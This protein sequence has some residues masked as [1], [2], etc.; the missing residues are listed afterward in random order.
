MNNKNIWN[1]VFSDFILV[2]CAQVLTV[3]LNVMS[4]FQN[5]AKY[6]SYIIDIESSVILIGSSFGTSVK[7]RFISLDL[8]AVNWIRS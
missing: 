8:T 6:I 4:V 2:N 3:R 5:A 7:N 1:L